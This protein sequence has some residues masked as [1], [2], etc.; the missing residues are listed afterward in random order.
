M[1]VC[2]I[3]NHLLTEILEGHSFSGRLSEEEEKL[4]I[5]LSKTCSVKRHFEYIE[6]NNSLNVSTLRTV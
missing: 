2:G 1:V 6:I 3:H 4:V 5:D